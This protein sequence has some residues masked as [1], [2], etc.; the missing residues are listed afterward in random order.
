MAVGILGVLTLTGGTLVYYSSTNLRSA[1][2]SNENASA[3][4]LAEAG[5]NE[6]MAVLSKPDNNALNKYLLGY[7]DGG[8]V[9][10]TMH[11]YSGGTVTWWGIL[12]E[13]TATWTLNSVGTI[14]NPTGAIGDVTR[15]LTAKVPVTPTVTQP[16]NNPA[17]NYL[18]ATQ[19][20]G[21]ECDL[22]LENTVEVKTRVYVAGNFCLKNSA[23][24]LGSPNV[25]V[26]V[27]G[28]TKMFSSQ[29]QIGSSTDPVAE[30][31]ID[32][33]CKWF[34]NG[35][36]DPCLN[37]AGGSGYDNVWAGLIS[38][39]PQPLPKPV[40]DWD[41][42]YLN[43]SPGPYYPC[44]TQSGT[45]PT[46][47]NDQG[48]AQ[49]PDLTKRNNSVAGTFNL[50]PATSYSCTTGSGQ[51]SWD[52]STNVLTV[53]GTIF[54][55]GSAKIENGVT[56]VYNGQAAIYLSGT[57]LIK[58]SKLCGGVVSGNCDFSA[59]DPNTE[60]L[61]FVTNGQNGQTDVPN[62]VGIEIKSSQFQGAL[63]A[64][65]KIQLDTT[66]KVDGPMVGET[67]VLGQSIDTDDF[68]TITT[69]PVGMPG[70][71]AVYAQPNPPQ[72]YS[73]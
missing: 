57:L 23:K 49:S 4:D 27:H 51:L 44:V 41:T 45:P 19:V 73:G 52:A 66:S 46:F 53:G 39:T 24:V 31:H 14:K 6:M 61:T 59:W 15:T 56:N 13:P 68:P 34:N 3:Y 8:T 62:G 38:S 20:S 50:T 26:V 12:D 48:S 5:I 69:V 21:G 72:L 29:N 67:I 63:Y 55:D 36:H 2:F 18:Y 32:D 70:N 7:E 28:Y 47:D 22:T 17:W 58:N 37:G 35:W 40:A 64:T 25:S 43:G 33:G 10:K 60:L 54:I 42:W 71:P 65:Y 1:E 16:L 9:E 30:A 11:D